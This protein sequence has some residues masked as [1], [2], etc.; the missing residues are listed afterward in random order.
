M[1]ASPD[2]VMSQAEYA[3]HRGVSRQ[4]IGKFVASGKI[5]PNAIKVDGDQKKIL[6]AAA[7]LALGET[8]ERVIA[9][10]SAEPDSGDASPEAAALGNDT[11]AGAQLTKA[12]TAVA[13][14][15]ANL[16]RVQYEE[17]IGKLVSRADVE[18]SMQRAA[19]MLA[20]DVDQIAARADDLATA[21]TR[22][23]VDGVRKFLKELAREI[24][25]NLSKNMRL[26][27]ESE[28]ENGANEDEVAA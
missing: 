8:I 6:V 15:Q 27:Q 11:G 25:G 16:A 17:K 26:L 22:D 4:A 12:R 13:F 5:P 24:R 7:D 9:R 19:E 3:R 2:I 28:I 21:F 1:N 23:G 18:I 14:Y 10:E 20:R